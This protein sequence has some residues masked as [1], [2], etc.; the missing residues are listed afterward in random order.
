MGNPGRVPGPGPRRTRHRAR[1]RA[2]G[3]RDPRVNRTTRAQPPGR[4]GAA[5][6]TVSEEH[7]GTGRGAADEWAPP[8]FV[9]DPAASTAGAVAFGRRRGPTIRLDGGLVATGGTPRDR[10]HRQVV[11]RHRLLRRRRWGEPW[12]APR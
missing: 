10:F 8:R 3:A 5:R 11:Y 9:V 7:D 4:L 12:R 2:A 1:A 6:L